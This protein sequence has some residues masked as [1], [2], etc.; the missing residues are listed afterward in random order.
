MPDNDE[1]TDDVVEGEESTDTSEEEGAEEES[2]ESTSE[3]SSDL[4]QFVDLKNVPPQFKEAAKRM[5]AGYTKAQQ[6]LR[7][8]V[9]EEQKQFESKLSTEF[10]AAVRKSKAFDEIINNP[11]FQQW[12]ADIEANRPYGYSSVFNKGGAKESSAREEASGTEEGTISVDALMEKITPA[13]EKVVRT[14]TAPLVQQHAKLTWEQ[15]EKSLP[16]IHKYKAEITDILQQFPNM[17]LEKAYRMASEEDRINEAVA[18]ALKDAQTT[19]D[20]LKTTRTE[21]G[22]VGGG[23]TLAPKTIKNLREA[24]TLAKQQMDAGG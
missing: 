24:I 15:A 11:N 1:T 22:N 2:P 8:K 9:S 7:A 19:T 4:G 20:K 5:L 21:K 17:P 14:M 6:N 10:S 13:I 18:K 12:W 16:N 3:E 23:K